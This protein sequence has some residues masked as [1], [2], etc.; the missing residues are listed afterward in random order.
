MSKANRD[1]MAW[2]SRV[3]QDHIETQAMKTWAAQRV[4]RSHYTVTP[5]RSMHWLPRALRAVTRWL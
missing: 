3:E 2:I 4:R 1:E 5:M